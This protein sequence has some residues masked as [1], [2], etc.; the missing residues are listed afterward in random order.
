[1]S[2]IIAGTY[3]LQQRI[4]SGGGGIVYLGRHLRLDKP[5]V[6]KADKRS[7][8]TPTDVLRREVDALKNLRHSY[9]PQVYDY[10][11][12]GDTVYTVMDYIEG[13]SLDQPLERGE[14]F[15]QPQVIEWG[16]ELLEALVYLHTQKPHGVLHCDIKPANI[17][18]T[19]HGDIRLIDY[20]IAY[21]LGEDETV[22]VAYSQ[23]YAS[24]E[25]YGRDLSASS[26]LD[27]RRVS[28]I[29][30][31]PTSRSA[32]PTEYMPDTAGR[33]GNGNESRAQYEAER[34]RRKILLDVRSDI[35]GVG[36]TLYH[37]LSGTRP[38]VTAEDVVP[39]QNFGV[40]PLIAAIVERA[41]QPNPDDRYQTAQ[42][43][44]DALLSL[45]VSD[46]RS[47]RHR[48]RAAAAALAVVVLL[49]SGGVTTYAGLRQME[50]EQTEAR[51]A[52][53]TEA[54]IAAEAEAKERLA[55]ETEEKAKRAL[56][57]VTEAQ[58]AMQRG[59]RSGATA[60]AAEALSLRTQYDTQ[61]QTVLTQALG[62]YDLSD[63]F[64]ASRTVELPSEPMKAV[65]SPGGTRMCVLYMWEMGV[66]D[67]STGEQLAALPAEK[68]ALA[69][70]VFLD[71]NRLAYAGAGALCV[72]DL[73]SERQLWAGD[74]ATKLCVSGDGSKI[75]AVYKDSSE[76]R[77]YDAETGQQLKT[78]S[79]GTLSQSVLTNDQLI[80]P[81]ESLLALNRDGT[82]L[83][84]S[85]S[86]GSMKAFYLTDGGEDLD[87]LES[88]EFRRFEG[89][90]CGNYLAISGFAGTD[91]GS[92]LLAVGNTATL[93]VAVNAAGKTPYHIQANETG[94]FVSNDNVITSFDLEQ[95][96]QR[97]LAY[98]DGVVESFRHVG[99]YTLAATDGQRFRIF[100]QNA[101]AMSSDPVSTDFSCDFIDLAGETAIVGSKNSP[102]VR[103]LRLE[104]HPEA[105]IA[106]YD[107]NYRH[108]EARVST[109]R[110]TVMLYRYDQFRVYTLDGK[111]INETIL[112]NPQQVTD[113]QYR[114]AGDACW[115][116]VLYSDGTIRNYSA[117]DGS[118]LS[119][120]KGDAPDPNLVEEFLTN[121]YRIVRQVHGA[122]SVY[123]RKTGKFI[124]ELES[125]AYL[126]YVTQVKNGIV[127]EYMAM[128]RDIKRY[129]LLLNEELETLAILPALCDIV[130]DTLIF[131]DNHGN[132]HESPIFTV[133]E[134]L[135]F[136][137]M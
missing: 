36:A 133:E 85:F 4:G 105:R 51:I 64:R 87:L 49:A 74:A 65:L 84:V 12:E 118:L 38:A 56:E 13:E 53:E 50:R 25:H 28:K 132:L 29:K 116:E 136:S 93:H 43:M 5:V 92:S 72:Y 58:D 106:S 30:A 119:E 89:G 112:P 48:H 71:E 137:K 79:F 108:S 14:R 17:M 9:I 127:T 113:Q 94:I 111:A 40:S 18:L 75:A 61:A 104:R 131:D 32:A 77:V 1:M 16:R 55:R 123:D 95:Q 101:K 31:A 15:S 35:Y 59:N 124:K 103:L 67:T 27:S 125:D 76:A 114:R 42:D 130:G 44:L 81:G 57:L 73:A 6:L 102:T 129:G 39:L 86:D 78:V 54:R 134:L 21:V 2:T 90:F 135:A 66:F 45:H 7:L 11:Q 62:V 20:N 97:E 70:A 110:Q 83:A 100:D 122:P 99:D 121:Q 52:A 91:G 96:S 63:G 26:Q 37:L 23:G 82:L 22:V 109:D 19:P 128:D 107:P 3:E 47:R 98:A 120:E 69:E 117:Q 34:T 68:S 41:M 8:S 33:K 24:P 88:S 126:V 46:A 60:A 80:D 10:V 115:L